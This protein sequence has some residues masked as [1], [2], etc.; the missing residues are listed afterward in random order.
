[1]NRKPNDEL[2]K[3]FSAYLDGELNSEDRVLVDEYVAADEPARAELAE[4]RT[5][6]RTVRSVKPVAAPRSF[7]VS[8]PAAKSRWVWARPLSAVAAAMPGI[9]VVTDLAVVNPGL[10]ARDD[11]AFESAPPEAGAPVSSA[12]RAAE[13]ADDG[14]VAQR[15]PPGEDKTLQATPPAPE[16]GDE[17]PEFPIAVALRIAQGL[18][19][20]ALLAGIA[21]LVIGRV[22]RQT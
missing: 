11:A 5:I 4:L 16:V 8:A 7:A 22:N 18:S 17:S 15:A 9:L 6:R 3:L 21:A 10:G 20:I 12:A 13:P 19:L 2:R 1:M 14:A